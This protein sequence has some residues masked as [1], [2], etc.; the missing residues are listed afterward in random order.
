MVDQEGMPRFYVRNLAELED[1]VAE[2]SFV[3]VLDLLRCHFFTLKA[4]KN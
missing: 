3:E 2:V 1:F 4:F